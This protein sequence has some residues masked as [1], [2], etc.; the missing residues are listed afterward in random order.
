MAVVATIGSRCPIGAAASVCGRHVPARRAA[1]WRR[2]KRKSRLAAAFPNS[3]AVALS[4]TPNE[5]VGCFSVGKTRNRCR[6][7]Q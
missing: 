3:G 1:R 2:Y 7:S 5:N 4:F 6:Q